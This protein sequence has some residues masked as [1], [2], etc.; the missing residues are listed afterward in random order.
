MVVRKLKAVIYKCVLAHNPCNA[1]TST[2]LRDTIPLAGGLHLAQFPPAVIAH[3][4][5]AA[6]RC[7]R[8]FV[9][10]AQITVHE[11]RKLA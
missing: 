1:V 8:Y 3:A 11:Y 10:S 5:S 4:S 6:A 7:Q 2:S 9:P